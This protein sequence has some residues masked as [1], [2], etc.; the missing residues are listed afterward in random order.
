MDTAGNL[1]FADSDQFVRVNLTPN[2]TVRTIATAD[3]QSL[4]SVPGQGGSVT[5]RPTSGAVVSMAVDAING[6]SSPP[7]GSP[8][9]V[10]LDLGGGTFTTD[11]HIQ[12]PAGVTVV[13]VNG[14]LVGG[15]PAPDRGLGNVV[16]RGVTASNATDAPTILVN[17]GTL[18]SATVRSRNRPGSPRPP[19][20]STAARWTSAPPP[21]PAGTPST[22]TAPAS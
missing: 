13:I 10:T 15:S 11:T 8:E 7:A 16:L 4:L 5:I 3:V 2:L 12:A 21:T 14:T 1:Y 18:T 19:S 6:L 20:G 17:G 22:S 9:T